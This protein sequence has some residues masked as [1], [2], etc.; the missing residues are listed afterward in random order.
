MKW[1][2]TNDVYA[3]FGL[4]STHRLPAL[5]SSFVFIRKG[6]IAKAI[7]ETAHDLLMEHEIP[8]EKQWIS[9]GRKNDSYKNAQPDE[10]YFNVA[11][12]KLGII[13][14]SIRPIYFRLSNEHPEYPNID[15]I[16]AN[17]Y[18]IGLFGQLQTNHRTCRQYYDNAAKEA[19]NAIMPF[20]FNNYCEKLAQSKFANL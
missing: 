11:L 15:E 2:K 6:K 10:L 7:F 17:H 1:A 20:Q 4:N 18:G 3:H 13:P 19:W 9:W 5:N 12:A 14:H 16:R 8:I